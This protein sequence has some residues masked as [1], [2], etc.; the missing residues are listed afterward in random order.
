MQSLMSNEQKLGNLTIADQSDGVLG[1]QWSITQST[2]GVV[3]AV[4][5]PLQ[6]RLHDTLKDDERKH[7]ILM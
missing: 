7:R 4:L 3:I 6:V 1:S 2:V 5:K